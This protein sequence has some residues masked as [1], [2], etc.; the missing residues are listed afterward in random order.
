MLTFLITSVASQSSSYPIILTR[1]GGSCS[2]PNPHL[3]YVEVLGIEPVTSWS[4][5]RYSDQCLLYC[6]VLK[7][8]CGSLTS[9]KSQTQDS[10]FK[11]PPGGLELRIF[12]SWKI[13]W[14]Q[15]SL[16]LWT[17]DLEASTLP[18]DHWG[19]LDQCLI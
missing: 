2:R 14:P 17:L 13:Y 11:V 16:N 5:V 12:T 3:K 7:G 8:A 9:L 19:R 10:Q 1:P 4:V 15:P 6:I 18:R